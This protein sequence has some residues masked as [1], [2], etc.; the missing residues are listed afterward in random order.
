[1]VVA[2]ATSHSKENV[3]FIFGHFPGFLNL[4]VQL[5]PLFI[6]EVLPY[7]QQMQLSWGITQFR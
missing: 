1:V 5:L 2:R 6:V 4:A 3:D 7:T